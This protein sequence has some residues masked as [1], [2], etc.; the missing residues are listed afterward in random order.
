MAYLSQE[1]ILRRLAQYG[2]DS[3]TSAPGD[4]RRAAGGGTPPGGGGGDGPR[5]AGDALTAWLQP[6]VDK[7]GKF[8]MRPRVIGGGIALAGIGALL[9]AANEANTQDPTL[10]GLQA[11]ARPIG[12]GVGQLATTAAGT[13]LGFVLGGPVGAAIGGTLGSL[14]PGADLGAGIAGGLAG[15]VEPS[16]MDKQIRDY[17]KQQ[18]AQME[19]ELERLPI[20]RALAQEQLANEAKAARLQEAINAQARASQAL[21]SGLNY[22]APLGTDIYGTVI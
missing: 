21:W 1:E 18:R 12:A 17:K 20:A 15:V 13:G 2:G 22:T 3:S 9:A 6:K 8:L 14:L 19:M 5:M 11:A 4:V 10:S 7:A 16:A